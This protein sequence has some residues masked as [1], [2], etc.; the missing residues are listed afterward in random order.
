M[1]NIRNHGASGGGDLVTDA[2][3][4][5]IDACAADGG[6]RVHVPP[7]E[8]RTGTIQLRGGVDLHLAGG[9]TVRGSADPGDYVADGVPH[10]ALVTAVDADDVAVT[11]RGTVHCNG[12]AFVDEDAVSDPRPGH[13]GA[14]SPERSPDGP[15]APHDDRPTRGLLFYRCSNVQIRDVT[16]RDSPHWTI[17]LLCCD[18]VDV[19]GA[20]VRNDL[21]IP[22]SD[23]INPDMSRNVHISDCTVEAGDDAVCLKADG[24]YPEAWPCEHVTVTNCTLQS[25]SCG[26][27]L[28]SESEYDIR[29][30]RFSNCVVYGSNRGLGIQNRDAGDVERVSFSDISVETRHHTG[31]WWGVAEPISVTSLPRTADTDLGD[32]RDVRFTDV[33]AEGEGSVVVYADPDRPVRN[34]RFDGVSHRV[35]AG[36]HSASGNELDLRPGDVEGGVR[37][38][39]LP[40]IYLR[41]VER[42]ELSDVSVEW[43]ETL[44]YHTHALECEGFADFLLDGFRGRQADDGA[45]V[46]LADGENAV[47]RRCIADPGTDVFLSRSDVDGATIADNVT[48]AARTAVR[49]G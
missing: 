26:I 18:E 6:G 42:A 11:G 37:E 31:D 32:V 20:D 44:P 2:L 13:F 41:G 7:G 19:R 12:L 24:R 43:D 3:Q 21:R 22:N 33:V 29:D 47:V 8:Y 17:H 38:R 30:C 15:L 34:L 35:T 48:D 40:A 5:A 1:E 16:V 27:K 36:E 10:R 28:G 4:A 9:A 39:D 49:T 45:A 14:V 23:G 25:R 46:A